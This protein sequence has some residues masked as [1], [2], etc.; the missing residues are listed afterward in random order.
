MITSI[1]VCLVFSLFLFVLILNDLVCFGYSAFKKNRKPSR[2]MFLPPLSAII[3]F[4][5]DSQGFDY[6]LLL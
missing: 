5:Q 2:L 4:D 1:F 6:P 3:P